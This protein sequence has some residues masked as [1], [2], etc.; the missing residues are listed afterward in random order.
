VFRFLL[1]IFIVVLAWVLNIWSYDWWKYHFECLINTALAYGNSLEKVLINDRPK[2]DK[3][4][5]ITGFTPV[6]LRSDESSVTA[7]EEV[8][9]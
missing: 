7:D 3:K 1:G 2:W 5:L 8:E 9:Q 4:D 6:K